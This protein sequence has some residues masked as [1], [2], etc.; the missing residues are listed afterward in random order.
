[1]NIS[2]YKHASLRLLTCTNR[3]THHHRHRPSG[4]AQGTALLSD[5]SEMATNIDLIK[6]VIPIAPILKGMLLKYN[7]IYS[8]KIMKCV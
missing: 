2:F 6:N 7:I 5:G 3:T 8:F 4:T 1:M